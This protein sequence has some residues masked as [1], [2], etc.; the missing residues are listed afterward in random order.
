V[1]LEHARDLFGKV[2]QAKK[3]LGGTTPAVNG[4]N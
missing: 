2:T 1:T 3:N 4:D